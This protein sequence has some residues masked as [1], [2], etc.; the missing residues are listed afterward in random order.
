[1]CD[2]VQYA[3]DIPETIIPVGQTIY[4]PELV[5]DQKTYGP[6]HCLCKRCSSMQTGRMKPAKF[7][8]YT[9]IDYLKIDSMTDHQYFICPRDTETF[10]FRIRKWSEL[11]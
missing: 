3:N 1:M 7:D 8:G 11:S 9:C 4:R 5:V 2:P 6:V 10:V